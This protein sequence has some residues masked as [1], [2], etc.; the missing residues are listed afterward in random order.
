MNPD[1]RQPCQICGE[2]ATRTVTNDELLPDETF[3]QVD[4]FSPP[5]HLCD[6]HS[7]TPK[8][9]RNRLVGMLARVDGALTELDGLAED[10]QDTKTFTKE[11]DVR[12]MLLHLQAGVEANLKRIA[13]A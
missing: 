6:D 12:E 1:Y 8:Q 5:W 13:D 9:Y 4:L 10:I 7:W 2:P 11:G 3:R